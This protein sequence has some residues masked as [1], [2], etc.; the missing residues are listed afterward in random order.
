M[1]VRSAAAAVAVAALLLSACQTT[2]DQQ[3]S[4]AV[5]GGLVGAAGGAGAATGTSFAG[6]EYSGQNMLVGLLAGAVVGAIAGGGSF[7]SSLGEDDRR[8]AADAALQSA[9]AVSPGPIHWQSEKNKDV[10][11]WAER[12]SPAVLDGGELCKRVKSYYYL[13]DREHVE[14]KRFC[15]RNERWTEA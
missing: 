15:F 5:A 7:W 6:G 13:D 10:F 2:G 14:T 1:R 9:N 3:P 4:G 8:R 11:G 12:A